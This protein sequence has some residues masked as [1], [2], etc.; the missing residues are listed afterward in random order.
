MARTRIVWRLKAFEEIRRDP[1]LR[2]DMARRAE[3]IAAAC[4][5]G[6]E[7]S[8]TD[9]KTRARASV[10]TATGNAMRSNARDNALLRNLDAG[11]G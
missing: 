7:S 6:F 5:E 10:I 3:A 1:A 11:R 8:S 2:R 4:G 9:G